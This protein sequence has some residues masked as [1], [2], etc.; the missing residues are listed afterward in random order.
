MSDRLSQSCNLQV[1]DYI[2]VFAGRY[3][4]SEPIVMKMKLLLKWMLKI[5]TGML[6]K[7]DLTSAV[8]LAQ[9]WESPHVSEPD[10]EANAG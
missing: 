8:S 3:T 9:V 1:N 2:T 4:H 10:A 7:V 5:A 6:L